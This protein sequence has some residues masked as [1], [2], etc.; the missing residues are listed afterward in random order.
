MLISP[1]TSHFPHGSQFQVLKQSWV[2]A[3][4]RVPELESCHLEVWRTCRGKP[5]VEEK[6]ICL[7]K[8]DQPLFYVNIYLTSLFIEAVHDKKV[9]TNFGLK[10]QPL[11]WMQIKRL[12]LFSSKVC[13]NQ[14][15][16]HANLLICIK[17]LIF[18]AELLIN[19]VLKRKLLGS[20]LPYLFSKDD[21]WML[22]II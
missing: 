10:Y 22:F 5:S 8:T 20:G 15:I 3:H 21:D 14:N 9:R 1:L 19:Q 2:L 17:Q 16:N 12:W 13:V 18:W 11:H 4:I 6:I 7:F